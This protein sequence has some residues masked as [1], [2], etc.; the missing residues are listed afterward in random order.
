MT[1]CDIK[2]IRGMR[3][4]RA[5]TMEIKKRGA[6]EDTIYKECAKEVREWNLISQNSTLLYW[7]IWRKANFKGLSANLS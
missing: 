1:I 5:L 4:A 6:G 7:V 3:Q 2:S